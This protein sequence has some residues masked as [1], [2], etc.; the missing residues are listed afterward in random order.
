MGSMKATL[1]HCRSLK[2]VSIH[3][4][5]MKLIASGITIQSY[6]IVKSNLNMLNFF[7]IPTKDNPEVCD[8]SVSL[9]NHLWPVLTDKQL[10]MYDAY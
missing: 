6:I 2:F 8:L 5:A 1:N 7:Q 10:E 9:K 3:A 4:D